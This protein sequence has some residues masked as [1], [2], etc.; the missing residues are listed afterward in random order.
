MFII[1]ASIL[2]VKEF[3]LLIQNKKKNSNNEIKTEIDKFEITKDHDISNEKHNYNI[4]NSIIKDI[5]T[6]S[7]NIIS[8]III[9]K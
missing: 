6:L 1:I 4:I 2:K 8:P 5:N 9:L 3:I 7:T